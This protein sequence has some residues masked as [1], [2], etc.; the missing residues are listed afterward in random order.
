MVCA[1]G[2]PD[3]HV[4]RRASERGIEIHA[5]LSDSEASN[6]F[7]AASIF[8]SPVI[9]GTGIKIKTLEAMAHGKPIIGFVDAFRGVPVEHGV[10]ALIANS[11]EEFARLFEGLIFDSAR[12]CKIG[13]AAREF[14]RLNFDPATLAARLMSV[15]SQTAESYAQGVC[16][17]VPGASNLRK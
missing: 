14:V 16:G 4:R 8:L 17:R 2:F 12:R 5:P 15:Y 6:L 11:P 10:Q 1:G 9:S 13:A 7:A 3:E